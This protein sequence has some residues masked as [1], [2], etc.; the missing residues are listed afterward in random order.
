ML[1]LQHIVGAHDHALM[2]SDIAA[3]GKTE[4]KAKEDYSQRREYS[5]RSDLN[6]SVMANL[7]GI[8]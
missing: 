8:V 3:E 4:G 7:L 6:Y 2:K 5:K 1:T